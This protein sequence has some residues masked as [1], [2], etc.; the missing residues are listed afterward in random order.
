MQ[1]LVASGELSR[2]GIIANEI[3]RI[4]K[5]HGK[6]VSSEY[7]MD[8]IVARAC[9]DMLSNSNQARKLLAKM[10][11]EE[12]Q[13]LKDRVKES[14]ENLISW[15]NELL[16]YYKSDSNEAKTLREY[17]ANLKSISKMWDEMLVSSIWANQALQKGGVTGEELSKE[18]STTENKADIGD[19]KRSDRIMENMTDAK[20][21]LKKLAM[22]LEHLVV[23]C[24]FCLLL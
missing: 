7:A 9:E 2:N 4:K 11:M 10:S 13:T 19:A 23:F 17:K 1:T 22:S 15:V 6:E 18:V 8:E 16:S 24:I 5:K 12:Q 3:D 20:K 21:L 14:L